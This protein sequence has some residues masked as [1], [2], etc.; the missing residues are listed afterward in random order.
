[1]YFSAVKTKDADDNLEQT[2]S[3]TTIQ[4]TTSPA[5]PSEEAA[6]PSPV[7]PEA[8]EEEDDVDPL[9]AY[10]QGIQEE[11]KKYR[12][13]TL[14]KS[15]KGDN[16]V[17]VV[18]G[19]AKKKIERKRGELMEQNQDAMEYSSNDELEKGDELANAMDNLQSKTK[20]KKP[21]TI[22]Q[23]DI[24]YIPFRK[25]FYIEVPEIT[26]MTTEEVEAYKTE[27]EG[28]KT[29]GKGCPRPIK[30]WAQCGVSK[31]LLDILKK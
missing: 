28:I 26:K 8:A 20:Q 2:T 25:N 19:V 27:M 4:S 9:D 21:L 13:Q 29:K 22:S 15:E 5:V 11:V 30:T 17:S 3:S 10:M 31:K 24:S 14:S 7:V 6:Q 16:K 12:T 18:V 1:M 23:D